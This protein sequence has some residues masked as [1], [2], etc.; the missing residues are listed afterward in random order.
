ME[1]AKFIMLSSPVPEND[2]RRWL[3]KFVA[4][5]EDLE[6]L[7]FSLRRFNMFEALR[8]VW[9][10]VRHSDFLAFLLDPQQT[11][12]LSDRFLKMFL[13][14]AL[15]TEG[16]T[17]AGVTPIDI[18]VWNLR[19]AVVQREWQNIDIIVHDETN[20]LFVLIEN[21]VQSQEHSNQ[22]ARY[23]ATVSMEYPDFQIV[24]IYLTPAGESSSDERFIPLGY[25]Q[26]CELVGRLLAVGRGGLD[27]GVIMLIEHYA[28][29]LRRHIVT[30]SEISQLCRRIYSKHKQALDLIY[31]HRPDRQQTV[32][33]LLE[34]WIEENA[35]LT[36]DDCVKSFVRFI[37]KSIDTDYL[38]QGS[39]WTSTG[40]M[41]L[42]ELA[43]NEASLSIKIVIGPGPAAIRE[44]IFSFATANKPLFTTYSKLYSKWNTIFSR[45]LVAPKSYDLLDDE[46]E[47]ELHV[48]WDRF[49][50]KELP[51]LISALAPISD[52]PA[53]A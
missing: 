45:K 2:P 32:R 18:D 13:Q 40:R 29:M 41:L 26:I 30:D 28:E 21:K 43:N 49:V 10:E 3:E 9:R 31:E 25:Q 4:Q 34:K 37:P 52:A 44:R 5:N 22:L 35:D 36:R 19:A 47:T 6:K 42:F 8:L 11:H 7:E 51:G 50:D 14:S 46:F 15:M 23:Y 16:L 27:S 53:S 1:N 24:P 38:R 17:Q 39:G 12:G 20:Q 33:E 48:Q